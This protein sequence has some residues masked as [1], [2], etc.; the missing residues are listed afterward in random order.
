M[1]SDIKMLVIGMG[2]IGLPIYGLLSCGYNL[3]A[4]DKIDNNFEEAS[5][6]YDVIH[7]CF[8][9]KE[10]E[11]EEFIQSVKDYQNRFLKSGGLTIIHST[12]AIGVC[13]ELGV[14]HSPIIGQHDDMENYIRNATKIFGGKRSQEAAEIFRRI[15]VKV[16]VYDK[17]SES[18]AAKLFLTESYRVNI[19]FCQRVKRLCDKLGLEFNNIYTLPAQIYN[20]IYTQMG[21]SEYVRPILAPNLGNLGGHCIAPNSKLIEKSE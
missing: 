16:L 2:E 4:Y 10:D 7:I 20:Q 3:F 9:H 12:T 17:A 14:V 6:P 5:V 11:R 8:G 21:H 13:D 18:E 1:K 19:E 15:G